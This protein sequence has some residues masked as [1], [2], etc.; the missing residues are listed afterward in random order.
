M[1]RRALILLLLLTTTLAAG[2]ITFEEVNEGDLVDGNYAGLTFT[3][4]VVLTAGSLLNEFEFPP[5]SGV[6]VASDLDGPV[7]IQF[8]SPVMSMGA[9]VT[10][11][12]PLSLSAFDSSNQLLGSAFSVFSSNLALSGDPGSLPN[13][14]L[15]IT[16]ASPIDHVT[17]TGSPSGGSFVLDD[18]SFSESGPEVVP[19]P[20]TFVLMLLSLSAWVVRKCVRDRKGSLTPHAGRAERNA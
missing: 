9:S 13:E 15:S 5:A 4:A 11:A 20:S 14:I 19:E 1:L 2:V 16:S 8:A 6:N 17:F 12:V 18:L 3:N 7:T 10:Y